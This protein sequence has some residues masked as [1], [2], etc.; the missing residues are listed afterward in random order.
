M[1]IS[2]LSSSLRAAS[3]IPLLADRAYERI[4]HDIMTSSTMLNLVISSD[5]LMYHWSQ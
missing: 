2:P 1:I 4:K 3:A 5:R